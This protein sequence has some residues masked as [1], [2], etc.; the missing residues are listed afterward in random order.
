M[1]T[2]LLLILSFLLAALAFS[3]PVSVVTAKKAAQKHYFMMAEK[4]SHQVP[5]KTTF[6]SVFVFTNA[7]LSTS[8]QDNP[9]AALFFIFNN[10]DEGGFIIISADDCAFP[11]IGYSLTG[12]FTGEKMP[13]AFQGMLERRA[14]EMMEMVQSGSKATNEVKNAWAEL[15]MPNKSMA[16]KSPTSVEA[17]MSTTWDQAPFY[18]DLCPYDNNYNELTVTGCPATAMAQIMKFWSY[19][20]HGTGYHSYNSENYGTLSANFEATNY[21]W[22]NMPNS[23]SGSN[24]AIATLMFHSGVAVEM[25]YG[26]AATGGSGG[27]VIEAQSPIQHCCE[28]AFKTYFGYKT[29]MQ[30]LFRENYNDATWIQMLKTDLDAGR[31]VQYAGFGQGGGHTWVCD[32]Y[33]ANNYF[34]M[35]WGWGG[36]YD[37]YFSLNNLA[38]GTGGAGGGSGNFNAGQQA[39][40][41]IEPLTGGSGGGTAFDLRAYSQIVVD[42]NPINFTY[43][44]SVGIQIGNYDDADFSG[45][46]A[47]WLFNEEG[48]FVDVIQEITGVTLP[49]GNYNTYY[50]QS[51]GMLAT[52][53]TYYIGI[54]YKTAGG[55][56]AIIGP[57]E[58]ANYTSVNI[59]G[60]DNTMQMYSDLVLNPVTIT[61]NEAF[62]ITFDIG[63]YDAQNFDGTVTA[64]L[65]DSEGGYLGEL[66]STALNLES[67]YYSTITFTISGVAVDAGSYILAI[68][69]Q[70]SGGDWT[71]VGSENYSNPI[72]IQIA[73]PQ[74][75]ADMYENND[76]LP[77]AYNFPLN[78]SGNLASIETTGSTI[79]NGNDLDFYKVDLPSGFEYKFSIR[80]H[81]SW[82]SGNGNT[83]TNDVLW[84]VGAGTWWSEVFDDVME[85]SFAVSGGQSVYFA[86]SNYYQGNTGTYL[87]QVTIEKGTFGMDEQEFSDRITLY[88]NPAKQ[89]ITLLTDDWEILKTPLTLEISDMQG[90]TVFLEENIIPQSN[91][92]EIALPDLKKGQYLL[93]LTGQK[94]MVRK[95]LLIIK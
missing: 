95:K 22:A 46:L 91:K 47:A 92:L 58:Y 27:Y 48:N 38:P 73:A 53:G 39:L 56:W 40:I 15:L 79:H 24:N 89:D 26:V 11:V 94:A 13:P 34:H 70:P 12:T 62:Q 36:T 49:L 67:G 42:P 84:A 51:E 41:G 1:K 81:D 5:D 33:D 69:D 82:N 65:Y 66:A 87:L 72:T 64:D 28:Y 2:T 23:L 21:D 88:P 9:N 18:N 74:L 43:A 16:F 63:N 19:P 45:N 93:S 29:T 86:V 14:E 25:Q 17:L 77:V 90:M 8:V 35:N 20:E 37:G 85:G 6:N 80:A 61:S 75:P 60:P 83:Y 78:F 68:W 71:L 55:D 57:G 31:P 3:E 4:A 50:F 30:G 44:F 59:V 32:G 7:G 10:N 76:D 54:Y 52:P